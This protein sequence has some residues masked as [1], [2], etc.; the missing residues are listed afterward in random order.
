MKIII[1]LILSFF[2][3]KAIFKI[4]TIYSN[5]KRNEAIEYIKNEVLITVEDFFTI[6]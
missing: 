5:K 3:T 6:K 1:S 4:F 2:I